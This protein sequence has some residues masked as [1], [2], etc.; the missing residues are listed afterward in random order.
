MNLPENV[1]FSCFLAD[2][3]EQPVLLWHGVIVQWNDQNGF[4]RNIFKKLK[5]EELKSAG[6]SCM[7]QK[8]KPHSRC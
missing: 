5:K 8:Q 2:P 7:F 1:I 3:G 6:R 4:I